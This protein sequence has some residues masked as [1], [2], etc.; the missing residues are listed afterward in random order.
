MLLISM[1]KLLSFYARNLDIGGFFLLTGVLEPISPYL[2]TAVFKGGENPGSSGGAC[3][4]SYSGG[5]DQE[6]YGLKP[7]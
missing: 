2:G 6:D 3:T 4:L 5:R 1:Q 7:V